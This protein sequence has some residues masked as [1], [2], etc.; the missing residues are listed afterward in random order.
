MAIDLNQKR[1][2]PESYGR[3][4][5]NL[6]GNILKGHGRD[7]TV[8]VFLRFRQGRERAAK[9]FMRRFADDYVTAAR[10][11]LNASGEFTRSGEKRRGSLF[12]GFYL[13]ATGYEFFRVP[14]NQVP[15][16]RKFRGGMKASSKALNDKPGEWERAYREQEIHAMILL[17]DDDYRKLISEEIKIVA[18]ARRVARV[19]TIERGTALRN[20]HGDT[21]EHFG[22]VDGASQ[23]LF[24][25]DEVEKVE[26]SS[27]I[28]QYDPSA[29]LKLALVR[30]PNRRGTNNFGSYF[31]FRKLEQNVE[32]FK[33]RERKLAKALGLEDEAA[34]RAG[35]L[36][37]GRFEDG[38]PVTL[39]SGEGMH[40]PV[41]NNFNFDEDKDGTKCPFQGHIRKV[42]PRG[43]S[44][45]ERAHRIVRRGITYGDRPSSSE[46]KPSTGVGLLFMCFQRDIANQFEWIQRKFAN[47]Q[48][49]RR[50][51]T[52]LD[53]V[54]GQGRSRTQKWPV[55]WGEKGA[56]MKKFDFHGFVTMKGGEYFFAPSIS[57]LRNLVNL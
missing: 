21:V 40:N 39:Q 7:H 23:P 48:N 2:D 53:P 47:N 43:R 42:N 46:D 41:F 3:M 12:G 30:E 35:A 5:R 14:R 25:K 28:Q 51:G 52:G 10:D 29:P 13:S 37:V 49:F 54:I 9:D 18:A 4:L 34:E 36:I 32:A 57:F 38:T 45:R 26:N 24:F 19:L 50:R 33:K 27:G 15:T 6:Q 11:Q 56:G 1:I 31:V 22:Y 17:A 20:D 8:H 55:D 44:A 16:D